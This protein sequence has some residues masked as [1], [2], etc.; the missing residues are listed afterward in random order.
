MGRCY[1]IILIS[2]S[3]EGG[4]GK[5]LSMYRPFLISLLMLA[6]VHCASEI[7]KAATLWGISTTTRHCRST[8]GV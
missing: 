6:A 5:A 7:E 4:C 1:V 2:C 3:P 8:A